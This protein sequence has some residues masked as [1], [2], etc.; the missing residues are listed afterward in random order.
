MEQLRQQVITM[1]RR[2][3]D[4]LDKPSDPVAGHLKREI[5]A[6]EDDLQVSKS[7]GTIE[8]RVKRIVAILQGDA[9][10]AQIMDIEHLESFR[11]WFEGLRQS[12]RKLG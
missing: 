8:E 2:V 4:S 10:R 3:N 12:V 6:L 7:A 1:Q 5:Q 11:Q 9:R